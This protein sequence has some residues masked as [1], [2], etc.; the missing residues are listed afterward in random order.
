M[1]PPVE[2]RTRKKIVFD[3]SPERGVKV[4]KLV[5]TTRNEDFVDSE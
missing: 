2:R 5:I 1:S 3:R 4:P